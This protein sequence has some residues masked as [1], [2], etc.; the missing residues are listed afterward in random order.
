[1]TN[2]SSFDPPARF[3][4]RQRPCKACNHSN[5]YHVEGVDCSARRTEISNSS[6]T[7][8]SEYNRQTGQQIN[9]ALYVHRKEPPSSLEDLGY[10]QEFIA[11]MFGRKE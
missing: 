2:L 8:R 10:T 9:E 3:E 5:A 4:R 11:K 1:M 6:N 7:H